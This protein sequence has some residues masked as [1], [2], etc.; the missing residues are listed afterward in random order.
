[1]S[2][3]RFQELGLELPNVPTPSAN[4]VAW[5]RDG[6]LLVLAGQVCEWN[7]KVLYTG[8]VGRDLDLG[9]GQAAARICGLNLIAA[10]KQACGS[11]DKVS[12]CLRLGGFVNSDPE[13]D[14]VPAVVN[15]ASNLMMEVFGAAGAHARTAVG[16]A[17]LPRRAAVEVDAIFVVED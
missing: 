6:N 15:G 5:R 12:G 4:Y 8:K 9:A 16:V 7:G 11:L 1:M 14:S 3:A 2:E 17:T 10:I 13:F